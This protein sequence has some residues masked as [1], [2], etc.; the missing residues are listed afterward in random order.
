MSYCRSDQLFFHSLTPFLP[1]SDSEHFDANKTMAM[2]LDRKIFVKSSGRQFDKLEVLRTGR[3][4][5]KSLNN[6]SL[7]PKTST[8]TRVLDSSSSSSSSEESKKA[9]N[10][11]FNSLKSKTVSSN[12]NLSSS[13]ALSPHLLQRPTTHAPANTSSS[14][15][16]STK[17]LAKVNAKFE[18][19][20]AKTVNKPR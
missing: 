11:I 12:N 3:R 6:L 20:K 18:V 14:T 9:M 15:S 10:G 4:H 8:T 2:T 13:S 5:S 17:N 16:T 1:S 7:F 19:E